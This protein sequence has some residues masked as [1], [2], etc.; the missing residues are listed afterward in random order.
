VSRCDTTTPSA[1]CPSIL[2]IFLIAAH[3]GFDLF[4]NFRKV[5]VAVDDRAI[6]HVKCGQAAIGGD[7]GNVFRIDEETSFFE[8]FI[9]EQ[10]ACDF[11]QHTESNQ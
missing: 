9:A 3:A 1:S 7:D 6:I 11:D 4:H 10:T 8:F 5:R 2:K